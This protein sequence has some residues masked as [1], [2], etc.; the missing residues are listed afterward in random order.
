VI[1]TNTPF[2][3][4]CLWLPV[5]VALLC[6]GPA[7][8]KTTAEEAARLGKD[9]TPIGAEKAG[10][11]A[12]TIPEWTGGLTAPPKDIGYKGPGF[13]HPDP[14]ASDPVLL[15][16]DANNI[17][18]YADHVPAGVQAL[19]KKYPQTFKLNVYK[20]RRTAAAPQSYYDNTKRN[21]TVVDISADGLSILNNGVKGGVPFPI[22]KRA[23][24]VMFNHSLRWRGVERVAEYARANIYADGTVSHSGGGKQWEHYAW[25]DPAI[26]AK[27][28]D[29]IYWEIYVEYRIP[30]RRKGELLLV[31]D[32]IDAINKPR[33][34][35]QYF[36]GQRR[37]RMAPTI[38]YDTPQTGANGLEVYDDVYVFNGALDRYDWKIVGKQEMY[39]PYNN[40]KVQLVP[41]KEIL[42]PHHIKPDLLRWE[43]HRVWVIEANLKEGKRHAYAKRRFYIDED[44]WIATISDNYDDRGN[45]W[46]MKMNPISVA[47]EL[48]G[49][50]QVVDSVYD[51]TKEEWSI[52]EHMN[53]FDNTW[54]R[55]PKLIDTPPGWYTLE[56]M[57]RQGRQ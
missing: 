10:N 2:K 7:L 43:L 21:A 32:N 3:K 24:E 34:A 56:N 33:L 49:A 16:I 20:T 42:Q 28:W 5:L 50:T 30:E 36:P 15:T 29:G 35:W 55:D 6:G 14:F 1:K 8:A 31:V 13:K 17:K 57:R 26:S 48:P 27:D 19:M 53:M 38:A 54:L 52:S 44:S 25:D 11:A 46:R 39:I 9:L 37:V 23:E 40:Y 12:G 22:P 45:L 47:Y 4:S 18:Q 41:E 51:M